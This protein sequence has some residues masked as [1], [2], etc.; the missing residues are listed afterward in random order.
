MKAQFSARR[1]VR[2]AMLWWHGPSTRG[3]RPMTTLEMVGYTL[4]GIVAL[5]YGI[6][7]VVGLVAALP[8]GI[9]GLIALLGIGVL[10]IKVIAERLHNREDDHYSKTIDQ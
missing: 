1:L 2:S 8:W 3:G 10:L 9:V 4:L 7:I 5:I 6:A